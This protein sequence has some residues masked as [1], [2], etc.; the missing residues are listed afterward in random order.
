MPSEHVIPSGSKTHLDRWRLRSTKGAQRWI[1][2][3]EEDSERH[4]QSLAKRYFLGL[5]FVCQV[6]NG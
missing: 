2:L 5:S 4:P 6:F 1:H 3:A